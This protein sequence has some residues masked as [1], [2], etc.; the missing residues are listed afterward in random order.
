MKFLRVVPA[1]VLVAVVS[2]D[3]AAQRVVRG[4]ITDQLSHIDTTFAFDRTGTMTV[5]GGSGDI[6]VSG[7]SASQ[8]RVR[9]E[10]DNDNVRLDVSGGR[11]Q[12]EVTNRRG[13]D[14]HIEVSVPYGVRVIVRGQSGDITV[15]ATRGP[16]EVHNQ[17]GDVTIDEVNGRLDAGTLSGDIT[18]G[19]VNGDVEIASTSGDVKLSDVRGNVD[20]GTVSGDIGL[21]GVTAKIVRAKT[22]SGDVTYDGAIDPAGRYDLA[23]H[24]GDVKLRIP[25]DASAQLTVST[26]NGE[27]DSDFPITL[28]PGEHGIG[29]MNSKKFTFSIG[30]GSA[31]IT[32]ETFSGDIAVS[33]NGRGARP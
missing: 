1:L 10:S 32:A 23:T 31:R 6:I 4:R 25:R 7:T 29:S 28:Q 22:T 26:W 8:A 33:S 24:S 21:R 30:G 16:V 11:A 13:G 18:V 5:N 12:V 27:I 14:A 3:A 20:V 17:S 9:A 15:R 19:T 2:R